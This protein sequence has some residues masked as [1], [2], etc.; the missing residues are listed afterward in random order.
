MRID[1][2]RTHRWVHVPKEV[3]QKAYAVSPAFRELQPFLEGPVGQAFAGYAVEDW[4]EENFGGEADHG[5][6][7]W[8]FREAAA[9][10]G[11]CKSGAEAM[12]YY[13]QVAQEINDACDR[14]LIAA[15]PKRASLLPPMD[16]YYLPYFMRA[17]QKAAQ[18]LLFTR[19]DGL[20]SEA[21]PSVGN[22]QAL[23]TFRE[24]T[25]GSISSTKPRMLRVTGLAFAP[26]SLLDLRVATADG[27]LITSSLTWQDS[28][29]L[30]MSLRSQ[31]RDIRNA[32]HAQFTLV[33]P[34][35]EGERLALLSDGKPIGAVPLDKG[36]QRIELPACFL[37]MNSAQ[38]EN[39]DVTELKNA[40]L[41]ILNVVALC[42]RRAM[43]PLACL[44]VAAFLLQ[45][46]GCL[47]GRSA[48]L[49]AI[50]LALL[51]AVSLPRGGSGRR[52]RDL[53]LRGSFPISDAGLSAIVDF[54]S[55][56]PD[57][58][59][60][61]WS[62]M[63]WSDSSGALK[64]KQQLPQLSSQVFGIP[65]YPQS[66]IK[67]YLSPPRELL[68][69]FWMRVQVPLGI[70]VYF[71]LLMLSL[72]GPLA[73]NDVLPNPGVDIRQ[74]VPMVVEARQA[75]EEG[76]FPLRVAP[77]T[78]NGWRCASFQFYASF[79]YWLGGLIYKFLTPGNPYVAVKLTFGVFGVLGGVYAYRC[80]RYVAGLRSLALLAGT[81]YMTAPYFLLNLLGRKHISEFSA[82]Q[83][84]LPVVIYY[85]LRL[86]ASRRWGSLPWLALWLTLLAGSHF[87]TIL[88]GS[89]SCLFSFS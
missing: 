87:V 71:S 70:F 17:L 18:M 53:P 1:H 57:R 59:L 16:S 34:E 73:R 48:A 75:I 66:T 82:S 8:A 74:H 22:E 52:R 39:D 10:A 2:V 29:G 30:Y 61:S 89:D 33:Y 14:G 31:G 67:Q 27:V 25:L 46:Y 19:L 47:R 37:L 9:A 69:R 62:R 55:A 35:V 44:A 24:M 4:P 86:Y 43:F 85:S 28:P 77:R 6:F 3:R 54:L 51:G 80:A 40:R 41:G 15:G 50:E 88:F 72:M 56:R 84:M 36:G 79:P 11:H 12:R 23:T 68:R 42:Y 45:C 63:V 5:H 78:H 26:N 60:A 20:K 81:V 83:G 58:G 38:P 21:L 13:A 7:W 76:Q 64:L 65:M 32:L 49:P